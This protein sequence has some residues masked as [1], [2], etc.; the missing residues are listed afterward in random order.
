VH[1]VRELKRGGAIIRTPSQAEMT[2]VVASAKQPLPPP[3][4]LPLPPPLM[5]P[6]LLPQPLPL[7]SPLQ[8]AL[9]VPLPLLPIR[10]GPSWHL[11]D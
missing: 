5:L 2:K 6:L 3:L 4:T 1:E 9:P 7:P 11:P 10:K 8:L